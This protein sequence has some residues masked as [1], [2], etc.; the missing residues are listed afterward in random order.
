LFSREF[1]WEQH[2]LQVAECVPVI[3]RS[4][5]PFISML[6][7]LTTQTRRHPV[8]EFALKANLVLNT[9]HCFGNVLVALPPM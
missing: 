8:S 7:H 6:L 3:H 4:P 5:L 1:L 9:N 2:I